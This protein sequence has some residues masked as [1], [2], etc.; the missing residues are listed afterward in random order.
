MNFGSD[1]IEEYGSLV[2]ALDQGNVHFKQKKFELDMQHR[3]SPPAKPSIEEAPKLELKPVP[4]H[5]RYLFVEKDDT[6]QVIIAS[7]FNVHQG[8][9][10]GLSCRK[11][12]K[13]F[14]DGYSGYNEISIT[15]EDQERTTFIC[16]YGTYASKECCLGYGMHQPHLRDV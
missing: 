10:D 15:S 9:N 6:L 2:A 12:V 8:S 5:L 3:E 16:P 13:N 7:D 4:P 1:C 11:G 14:L